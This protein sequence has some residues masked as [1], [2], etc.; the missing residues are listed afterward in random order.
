[1]TNYLTPPLVHAQ[2]G[3]GG[4]V[5]YSYHKRVWCFSNSRDRSTL[6]SNLVKVRRVEGEEGGGWRQVGRPVRCSK[7]FGKLG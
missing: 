6:R 1:M 3:G 5:V 7:G 2:V 4:G